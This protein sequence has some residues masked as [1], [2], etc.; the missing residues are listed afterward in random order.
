MAAVDDL[1]RRGQVV[2]AHPPQAKAVGRRRPQVPEVVHQVVAGA[3]Q[4]A[5]PGEPPV[6]PGGG[7]KEGL[8]FHSLVA[9]LGLG[10]GKHRVEQALL[11]ALTP[12]SL[13]RE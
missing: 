1:G 2:A 9:G 4:E 10:L 7:G 12:E 13:C 6:G 8:A 3:A 11:E 5:S